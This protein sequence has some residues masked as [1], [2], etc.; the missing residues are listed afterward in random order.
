MG[1]TED[2]LGS[3]Y[4][5]ISP[6]NTD[7]SSNRAKRPA[8]SS[9][10][11]GFNSPGKLREESSCF[12]KIK[13]KWCKKTNKCYQHNWHKSFSLFKC[14]KKHESQIRIDAVVLPKKKKNTCSV[15]IYTGSDKI[16]WKLLVKRCVQQLIG[17]LVA[18]R[19]WCEVCDGGEMPIVGH[20]LFDGVFHK[21]KWW[22]S[23]EAES[24]GFFIVCSFSSSFLPSLP[25]ALL[26][27]LGGGGD[28]F[29]TWPAHLFLL[30]FP[31]SFFF[32]FCLSSLLISLL[33]MAVYLLMMP[34]WFRPGSSSRKLTAVQRSEVKVTGSYPFA[35]F[36]S[37]IEKEI[38][39]LLGP[40]SFSET[41]RNDQR[42]K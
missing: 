19:R 4:R 26:S 8:N 15:V 30:L 16:K 11:V 1:N 3:M 6:R 39:K 31:H 7:G 37:D 36:F 22:R 21:I 29:Q 28:S 24:W 12:S 42:V 34:C 17:E 40:Q 18:S 23:C 41:N 32:S 2:V 9:T 20:Q 35:F 13:P 10:A 14:D 25:P 38:L 27:F 5:N 33:A